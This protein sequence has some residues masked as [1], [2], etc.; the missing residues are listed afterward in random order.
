MVGRSPTTTVRPWSTLLVGTRRAV[1]DPISTWVRVLR[2]WRTRRSDHHG[3]VI[4]PIST[5]RRSLRRGV[6][7][8]AIR[9]GDRSDQYL[10]AGAATVVYLSG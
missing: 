1:I 10:R 6:L 4:D 8:G 9:A 2:R 5:W 7:V 3:Q